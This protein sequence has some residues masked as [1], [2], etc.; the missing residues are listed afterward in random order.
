MV[1]DA[2]QELDSGAWAEIVP[3]H[4]PCRGRGWLVSD[5]D[6][7][8]A[9]PVHGGKHVPHPEDDRDDFDWSMHSLRIHRA[10]WR[11]L[12]S[13]VGLNLTTFYKAVLA[14]LQSNQAHRPTTPQEWVE[15]AFEVSEDIRRAETEAKAVR[16]GYS[17]RLEAVW[18]ID[19]RE[20][21]LARREN[22]EPDS[23][24]TAEWY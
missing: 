17:C 23:N 20:E 16:K 18:A 8:H 3:A 15:A 11:N 4:C 13:Q 10:A 2:M 19:G 6:T 24:I 5:Y 7:A 12:A 1:A 21:A 9:C 14:F 22:R